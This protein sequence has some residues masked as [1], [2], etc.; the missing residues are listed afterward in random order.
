MS[1]P[2][3]LNIIGCG[4]LGTAFA[5]LWR[6]HALLQ[7]QG[8][9]NRSLA[10]AEAA[11]ALI[12]EGEACSLDE[13]RPAD[14]TMLAT[15]DDAIA[16]S[17][18]NLAATGILRPGDIVFH[19]SGALSSEVLQPV[20]KRGAHI[21]SVHPIKSFAEPLRAAAGFCG[22]YCGVEGEPAATERLIPLFEK[23]GGLILPLQAETKILYHAAMSIGANYLATL[24][25][26]SLDTLERAGLP[27]A[28][29]LKLLEP[30]VRDT[31]DNIFSLGP[32]EALTGPIARRDDGVV[33][34]HIE[35]LQAWRPELADLYRDLGLRTLQLAQ[36]RAAADPGQERTMQHIL[37]QE[38]KH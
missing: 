26:M 11:V 10:S 17:A 21:A 19:C 2:A 3:T 14:F 22:T 18:R 28:T 6:R 8:V 7:L 1:E 16:A 36:D 31:L 38:G 4:R 13:L 27:P 34:R 24:M 25:Q 15:G 33:R 12:G 9:V 30:L 29:G 37:K 5:C 23:I 20:R 35:A 32:A